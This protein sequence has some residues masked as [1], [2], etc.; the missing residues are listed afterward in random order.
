[1]RVVLDTNVV[2]SSLL[3][4]H[5]P[6]AELLTQAE[7]LTFDVLISESIQREYKRVIKR[8]KFHSYLGLSDDDVDSLV[9]R[10]FSRAL[11][12]TDIHP[13]RAVSDDPNDD[14]FI[15]CAVAGGADAIVSGDKHLLA[16]QSY[17][18]IRILTPA[19]F[20]AMLDALTSDT[21]DPTEQPEG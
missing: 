15:E 18:E 14:K 21:T 9:D 19:Q 16:L 12:V 17:E 11:L 5:S 3:K 1:M 4:T 13:I 2:V 7:K 20:V 6:L 10:L 8:P